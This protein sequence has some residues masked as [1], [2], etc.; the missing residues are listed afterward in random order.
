MY[1]SEIVPLMYSLA[2][3]ETFTDFIG[4]FLAQS[5][6]GVASIVG[7]AV[8]NILAIVAVCGLFAGSVSY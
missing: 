3:L 4:L 5:D 7:S 1:K 6:V 2:I 8:F